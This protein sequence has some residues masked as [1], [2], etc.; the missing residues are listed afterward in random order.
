MAA[1]NSSV[2]RILKSNRVFYCCINIEHVTIPDSAINMGDNVFA[3][4]EK[5]NCQGLH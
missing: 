1:E 3:C 2:I 4:C 5:L